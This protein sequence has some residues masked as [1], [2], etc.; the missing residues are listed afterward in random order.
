MNAAVKVLISTLRLGE[1]SDHNPLSGLSG[2]G[3]TAGFTPVF[4]LANSPCGPV[5]FGPRILPTTPFFAATYQCT[6]FKAAIAG[7]A[8][9][10]F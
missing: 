3:R 6:L 9:P 8:E 10:Q 7:R 2:Q 4:K 1:S 5:G